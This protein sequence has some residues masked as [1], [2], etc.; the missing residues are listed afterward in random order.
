[1]STLRQALDR[2]LLLMRDELTDAVSDDVLLDALVHTEIALV[3]DRSNLLSHSAQTA[4]ATAAMLMARSGHRVYLLAPDLPMRGVQPPLQFGPLRSALMGMG[5]DILPGI[6]FF[7]DT[8]PD[9]V[10]LQILFGD[11]APAIRAR[12]TMSISANKW[13]G[14]LQSSP[15]GVWPNQDWP[16]GGLATAALAAAEAFKVAMCKL[17]PFARDR[18]NFILRF[19]QTEK[20][21]FA[22]APESTDAVTDLGAFD[23]ISAGAITNAVLY[24]LF[25][26]LGVRGR[27]RTMDD[28]KGDVSNLNRYLLLR[29]SQHS[30]RKSDVLAMQRFND[31]Q[32]T[33]VPARYGSETHH[34]LNTF[35]PYVIVGVDHIP[36]RWLVQRAKPVWL[37][38]GATTHWSAMAS[39]HAKGLPCAGCLHPRYGGEDVNAI[40]TVAFVSLWA[41]LLVATYFLSA[42]AEQ[43]AT[44]NRQHVYLT[45]LRPELPWYSPIAFHSACPVEHHNETG[46]T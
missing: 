38:I 6:T 2:T 8:V 31:L 19:S 33:P 23:C 27:A 18:E 11:S 10:D 39:F 40:P 1:M 15:F 34:L 43:P 37:G 21:S 17:L 32:I 4:F 26:I 14:F 29:Y 36:T 16:L 5:A 13:S 42:K 45:A 20:T 28:D 7:S 44:L 12:R 35:S 24:S 9:C 3:A 46:V 25:R 30:G 41:G 22:L